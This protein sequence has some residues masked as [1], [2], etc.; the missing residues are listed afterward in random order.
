MVDQPLNACARPSMSPAQRAHSETHIHMVVRFS[1]RGIRVRPRSRIRNR[2][3]IFPRLPPPALFRESLVNLNDET[4]PGGFASNLGDGSIQARQFQSIFDRVDRRSGHDTQAGG[5]QRV[6]LVI[7]NQGGLDRLN[8]GVFPG[9]GGRAAGRRRRT[10]RKRIN[11]KICNPRGIT[12]IVPLVSANGPNFINLVL[13][14]LL[15][16]GGSLGRFLLLCC[17]WFL[18]L[19][20]LWF[21]TVWWY[22]DGL[23][24]ATQQSWSIHG[25]IFET[26]AIGIATLGFGLVVRIEITGRKGLV[27]AAAAALVVVV[28]VGGCGGCHN[29]PSA[30]FGPHICVVR[31]GILLLGVLLRRRQGMCASL[32]SRLKSFLLGLSLMLV[33]GLELLVRGIDSRTG[34]ETQQGGDNPPEI[35]RR[36]RRHIIVTVHVVVQEEEPPGRP[37]PGHFVVVVCGCC[38]VPWTTLVDVLYID[39]VYYPLGRCALSLWIG[40]A[41]SSVSVRLSVSEVG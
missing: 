5:R 16:N 15:S 35:R 29:A 38:C 27:V 3:G 2:G 19:L 14:L 26:Q 20:W 18:L 6:P 25:E 31:V 33:H 4:S 37:R 13:L 34:H 21:C 11:T 24:S 39:I 10:R 23:P 40:C 12:R 30:S 41:D 28:V 17:K 36:R 7:G 9:P 8:R 32:F 22:N 1:F